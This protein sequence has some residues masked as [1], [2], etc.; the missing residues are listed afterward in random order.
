[1]CRRVQTHTLPF[2]ALVC[3]RFFGLFLVSQYLAMLQEGSYVVPIWELR[4]RK[5]TYLGTKYRLTFL[6]W[7]E[8][9][10]ELAIGTAKGGLLIHNVSRPKKRMTIR[11]KHTEVCVDCFC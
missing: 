2:I 3:D 9:G 1:M 11:A 7:S 10:H 5:M 4:T 6:K 8:T